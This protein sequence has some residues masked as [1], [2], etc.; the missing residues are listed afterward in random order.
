MTANSALAGEMHKRLPAYGWM[1]ERSSQRRDELTSA[2]SPF[3]VVPNVL[4]V[5]PSVLVKTVPEFIAYAKANPG[6]RG[7]EWS[8]VQVADILRRA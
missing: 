6:K 8:A 3:M 4:V 5:H 1:G 7:G 2:L